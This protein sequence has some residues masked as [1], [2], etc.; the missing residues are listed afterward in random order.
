MTLKLKH[1]TSIWFKL[2]R[3]IVSMLTGLLFLAL[4]GI[5]L[6]FS[7][8]IASRHATAE[9][10]L[11]Q[12]PRDYR[13][14][15]SE[16]ADLD[17]EVSELKVGHKFERED[18]KSVI[19]LY[20][21]RETRGEEVLYCDGAVIAEQVEDTFGGWRDK[22]VG[23]GCGSSPNSGSSS[24]YWESL[25]FASPS[26]YYYF[27]RG[28]DE[29]AS[30]VEIVMTDGTREGADV[31][32]GAYALLVRR[33]EPFQPVTFQRLQADGEMIESYKIS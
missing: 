25:P 7:A 15:W 28:R 19:F 30:R 31:V 20:S 22:N 33:E 5:A 17:V 8:S 13:P 2:R 18:L 6:G 3:L 9:D 11:T 4:L 21:W 16:G 10:V 27:K 26:Y 29:I 32:N 23:S 14:H 24:T 1:R 12:F